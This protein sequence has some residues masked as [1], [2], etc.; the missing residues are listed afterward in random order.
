M[1]V[2]KSATLKKIISSTAQLCRSQAILVE[3][4]FKDFQSNSS[5]TPIKPITSAQHVPRIFFGRIQHFFDKKKIK[6]L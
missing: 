4:K 2:Y 5:T 6:I 1:E 3:I